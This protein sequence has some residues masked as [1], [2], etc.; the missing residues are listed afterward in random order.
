MLEFQVEKEGVCPRCAEGKIKR[1]PF[2]SSQSKT[3]D[4]LQ[5]VH[6]DISSMIPV[7]PLGGYSYYFTFTDDYSRNT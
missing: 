7:K 5:L 1:G 3:S 6:S 2:P 4:I